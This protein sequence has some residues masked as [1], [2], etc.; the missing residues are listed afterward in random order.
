M[1]YTK[2]EHIQFAEDCEDAG[3]EVRFYQGRYFWKGPAASCDDIQD[4]I[5]ATEVSVQ[6][7]QLGLGYIVYP[8]VSDDGL[9]PEAR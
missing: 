8:M 6:W 9:D 3:F 4:V 7:D 1:T 2:P 5:R